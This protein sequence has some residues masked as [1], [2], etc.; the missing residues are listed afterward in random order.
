MSR[1][2]PALLARPDGGERE[3]TQSAASGPGAK[4]W[5][6]D[7]AR[8][9]KFAARCCEVLS[10][11]V[12][13]FPPHPSRA[14]IWGPRSPPEPGCWQPDHQHPRPESACDPHLQAALRTRRRK[15]ILGG[16][17]VLRAAPAAST[18]EKFWDPR[19]PRLQLECSPKL[20]SMEHVILSPLEGTMYSWLWLML[21]STETI[22]LRFPDSCT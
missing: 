10:G 11:V 16:F 12:G 19:P 18:P 5:T 13:R 14:W 20:E 7:S 2:P 15:P 17:R 9:A 6:R 22:R 21:P 8:V 1:P 3:P 4:C